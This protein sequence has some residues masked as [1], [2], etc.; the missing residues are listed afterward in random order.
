MY[1]IKITFTP[2][3][4][5]DDKETTAELLWD[6]LCGLYRSGQ[7][8]KDYLLVKNGESYAAFV[9]MPESNS[10]DARYSNVYAAKALEA[11]KKL[12]ELSTEVLGENLNT[13]DSC[14]CA[15]KPDWYMLYTSLYNEESPVA[16]GRCGKSVPL[17]KMPFI[18]VKGTDG[19]FEDEHYSTL[20]WQE[21]YRAIDKLWMACLADRFTFRQMHNLDSILS[22]TG[23][24]ICKEYEELTDI[25]CYYYLYNHIK[26]PK[27]C[28]SCGGAWKL[29]GEETFIDY[30]CE[31]CRLVADGA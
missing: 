14:T 24:Y 2:R 1:C 5:V 28:P 19:H 7:I 29:R 9:T 18:H 15:E 22:K 11:L 31:K 6:Y 13:E 3:T 30:K 8:L 25:P 21:D 17:Y 12:F 10:L 4:I 26:A 20:S 23:R 16:C 27:A